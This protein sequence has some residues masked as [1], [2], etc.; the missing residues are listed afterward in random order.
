MSTGMQRLAWTEEVRTGSSGRVRTPGRF[1]ECCFAELPLSAS[2][3]QEDEYLI[4]SVQKYGV[5]RWAQ[6]AQGLPGRTSKACSHR[7]RTYLAPGVKHT[8]TDP[9]TDWEIAVV[10][11]V[12]RLNQIADLSRL[13]AG[14][15]CA[16]EGLPEARCA[17]PAASPPRRISAGVCAPQQRTLSADPFSR[18][19]HVVMV[20]VERQRRWLRYWQRGSLLPWRSLADGH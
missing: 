9:F 18:R 11:E 20:P 3:T 4:A 16:A 8:S 13:Y 1:S 14:M 7:W 19:S 6:I 2:S 12:R 17:L 15:F 10:Q 5:K